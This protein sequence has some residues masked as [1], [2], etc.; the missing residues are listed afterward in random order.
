[1]SQLHSDTAQNRR[2]GIALVTA[3][4]LMFAVLDTSAKWLVQTVPVL[5]VVWLRFLLHTL[6]TTAIFMPSMGKALFKIHK[7][8]MQ[9]LLE[10]MLEILIREQVQLLLDIMQE[11]QINR[12][13]QLLLDIM[14]DKQIK[15]LIRLL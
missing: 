2:I 9:L 12:R 5:Q 4:T 11:K 10:V 3:T 1:M 15:V 7:P 6:L 13:I 8:K 14:Q